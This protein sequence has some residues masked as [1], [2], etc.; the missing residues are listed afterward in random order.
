[1]ETLSQL[2][3]DIVVLN[4]HGR[5]VL[6]VE[7]KTQPIDYDAGRQQL[8]EY[9]RHISKPHDERLFGLLIDT[10]KTR[11]FEWQHEA[12]SKQLFADQTANL[13]SFY[14][15]EFENKPIF[16]FYLTTLVE[17]WLRDCAYHWKSDTPPGYEQLTAVG[18]TERLQGGTTVREYGLAA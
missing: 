3:A 18:L 5:P 10:Q 17:A 7:V 15:P 14:D 1:M 8:S 13:L 6:L 9:F 4:V 12:L 16:E 2:R 11:L